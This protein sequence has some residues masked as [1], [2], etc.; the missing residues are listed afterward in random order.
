MLC[1][2]FLNFTSGDLTSTSSHMCG[3]WFLPAFL[4]RN[5]PYTVINIASLMVLAILWSS[6]PTNAKIVQRHLMTSDVMMVM[7]GW[8]SLHVFSE[9]V[10]KCSARFPN[11]FFITVLP[12]TPEPVDHSTLLRDGTSPI[13]VYQEFLDGVAPFEKHFYPMFSVDIFAA[14]PHAL[15]VWDNYVGLVVTASFVGV[16]DCPL[17]SVCLPLLFDIG[18]RKGPFWVL[19]LLLR[20]SSSSFSRWWLEQTVLALCF[21]VLITLN[22]A[23]RWWWLFHCKYRFVCVGFLY[24]DVSREPS[25]CGITIVSRK[26]MDPSVL[27]S[28]VVKLICGSTLLMC[29]RKLCFFVASMTTK[30]SSIYLFQIHGG[31]QLCWWPCS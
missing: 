23:D 22:F 10:C 17:N 15:D 25:G 7:D 26:G 28:S 14:L 21:K 6:L 8:W 27:P 3:S 1:A 29:S 16:I 2:L 12:A 11:I 5:G 30:V 18:S 13:M 4:F 9:P 24:T 31:A 20:W 19:R